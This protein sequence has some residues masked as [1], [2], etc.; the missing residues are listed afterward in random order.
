MGLTGPDHR[1]GVLIF[2]SEAEHYAE[3][4]ADVGINAKVGAARSG[5]KPLRR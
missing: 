1:T 3:I 2:A 5:T 4:V